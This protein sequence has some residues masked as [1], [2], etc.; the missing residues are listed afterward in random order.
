MTRETKRIAAKIAVGLI[1]FGLCSRFA[2]AQA[3]E[4]SGFQHAW[5]D[6]FDGSSLSNAL[7]QAANTNV[8]TNNSLQDY[9]PQ[10]VSVGDGKLIITSENSPS[11]GLPYRSGLVT[12]HRKQQYGRWEVRAKLPSSRGMWPA[13]WLLSDV[14]TNPWPS[15]GEIDIMENRGDEPHF[16]SSAFHYGT[17]LP[18]N[19]KFILREQQN[20]QGGATPNYHNEFHDYAVE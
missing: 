11:R 3:P 1:S 13:I 15:Q 7:W 4:V 5:S 10:Q 12:S 19:H 18:F 17:N 6:T 20:V 2:S 14:S 16:T 8:P 9:L